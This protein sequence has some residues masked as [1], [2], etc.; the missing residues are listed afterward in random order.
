MPDGSVACSFGREAVQQ[1][2]FVEVR[3]QLLLVSLDASTACPV[4][5]MSKSV[6]GKKKK[7]ETKREEVE[8]VYWREGG[9]EGRREGGGWS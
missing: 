7:E 2:T 5:R 8:P 3:A 9:K 1:A 4:V 6:E